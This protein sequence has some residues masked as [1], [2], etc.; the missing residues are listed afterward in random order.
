M[1]SSADMLIAHC[2]IAMDAIAWDAPPKKTTRAS[3]V[4]KSRRELSS[5][6]MR[7]TVVT[8]RFAVKDT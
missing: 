5:F 6:S 3:N 2:T 1:P 8:F 4:A 7:D